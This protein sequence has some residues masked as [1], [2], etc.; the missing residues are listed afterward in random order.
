MPIASPTSSPGARPTTNRPP[1]AGTMPRTTWRNGRSEMGAADDAAGGRVL[2][3]LAVA[4][5]LEDDG[6]YNAA[7]LFRAAALGEANRAT[8]AHPGPGQA[9]ERAMDAALDE[10]RRAGADAAL[11]E[12]LEAARATVRAGGAVTLA[13]AP[14]TF[15]CR[16]CGAV[17]LGR[18]PAAC[19]TCGMGRLTFRELLPTYYLEPLP[20]PALA[21]A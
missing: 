20:L 21:E 15:V 19:P 18:P 10:L 13:E 4:R 5:G 7:K 12:R 1:R 17:A 6:Q 3:L 2:R 14:A 11:L 16:G 9:L 8:R